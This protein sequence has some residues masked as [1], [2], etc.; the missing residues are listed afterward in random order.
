TDPSV[1]YDARHNV[2]MVSTLALVNT[3]SGPTGKAALTSRSTNGGSTWLNPVT[4]ASAGRR[5]DFDKN[6]IV[7]DN[8]VSSP[9][10]GSCSTPLDDVAG[11]AVPKLGYLGGGH[12]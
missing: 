11:G 5:N 7:C 6:W 2:W 10:Y 9:F 4:T 3:A 12:A 1:A 8:T